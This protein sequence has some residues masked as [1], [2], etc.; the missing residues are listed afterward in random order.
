MDAVRRWEKCHILKV[1]TC[2]RR[3][4][5]VVLDAE[6][7]Y[8]LG[9]PYCNGS[10]HIEENVSRLTRTFERGAMCTSGE[11]DQFTFAHTLMKK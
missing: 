4:P 6:R 1:K 10:I 9:K 11:L 2:R 3:A 7:R 8:T 5:A